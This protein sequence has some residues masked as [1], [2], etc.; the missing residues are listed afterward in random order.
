[1]IT[2]TFARHIFIATIALMKTDYKHLPQN[3]SCDRYT[4][5]KKFA[6]VSGACA[7]R[8]IQPTWKRTKSMQN[9]VSHSVCAAC[10]LA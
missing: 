5:H 4:E 7:H 9:D 1:M 10:N 3:F 2:C 6:D 8:I